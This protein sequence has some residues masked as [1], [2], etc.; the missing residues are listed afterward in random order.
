LE[1]FITQFDLIL[2]ISEKICL[3]AL[4]GAEKSLYQTADQVAAFLDKL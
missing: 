3:F 2:Q 1:V 4:D